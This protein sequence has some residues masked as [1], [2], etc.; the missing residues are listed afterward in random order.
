MIELLV[1]GQGLDVNYMEELEPYVDQFPRI[2]YVD[3]KIQS[4]SPFRED[5]HPSFAVNLVNGTWVDSGADTEE[6]RKGNFTS[7]LYQLRQ[8]TYSECCDYLLEKYSTI[9]DD[10]D[11]LTLK[12]DLSMDT[13]KPLL[14][15]KWDEYNCGACEYLTNRG[16]NKEIQE[17]FSIGLSTKGDA[18]VIP[19][20]DRY[21]Q[22]INIKY[23]MIATKTF[24]YSKGGRP[25]K[26][27]LYGGFAVHEYLCKTVC[28]TESEIDCLYL[29]TLGIPAV[30]V[31]GAS[32]SYQQEQELLM[33]G[34]EKLI[35]ATD[36]DTVGHRFAD[37]IASRLGGYMDVVRL[38]LPPNKKD[39][40][41]CDTTEILGCIGNVSQM[42]IKWIGY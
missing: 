21:G 42:L 3:N 38:M 41:E 35:V 18:V 4:C 1:R 40:N 6:D 14:L 24:F 5:M 2:K 26:E 29:W 37:V 27:C 36:M 28:I 30:A 19:W 15:P 10:A 22:I 7:L 13:G 31:G 34:I 17:Y 23:R 11:I 32:L 33:L 12:M 8:E 39:V 20:H 25:I 16:I 9:Y